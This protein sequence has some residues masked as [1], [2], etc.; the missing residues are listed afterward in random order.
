M[1]H[2]KEA[3]AKR[4]TPPDWWRE[5]QREEF[6]RREATATTNHQVNDDA[7]FETYLERE[8]REAFE[9]VMGKLFTSLQATGQAKD[10]AERNAEYMARV[11]L[12]GRFNQERGKRR[13]DDF[14]SVS[15]TFRSRFPKSE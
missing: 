1:H 2:I 10:E 15:D 5:L 7:E 13:H 8:G 9:R 11:N 12:R 14:T 6:K 4:T 3:A